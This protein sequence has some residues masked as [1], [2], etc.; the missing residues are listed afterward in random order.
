MTV[1]R[2]TNGD[3]RHS[4]NSFFNFVKCISVLFNVLT[5]V[6]LINMLNNALHMY[7]RRGYDRCRSYTIM[8]HCILGISLFVFGSYAAIIEHEANLIIFAVLSLIH[9]LVAIFLEEYLEITVR[10]LVLY[11]LCAVMSYFEA[12]LWRCNV[13]K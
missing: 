4:E 11:L 10:T 2:P 7:L 9:M 6:T 5:L 1:I 3:I 8:I 12:Y 13:Q